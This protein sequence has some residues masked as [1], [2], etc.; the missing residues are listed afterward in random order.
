LN[1][2]LIT[3]FCLHY[4][5]GGGGG[6]R[7]RRRGGGGGFIGFNG[8]GNLHQKTKPQLFT[9]AM[10]ATIATLKGKKDQYQ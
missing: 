10:L 5:K 4:S 1:I 8:K 7:A 3:H 2:E 9:S 6:G